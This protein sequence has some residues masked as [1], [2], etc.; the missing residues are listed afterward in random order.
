[1]DTK[2]LEEALKKA[3]E[4]VTEWAGAVA[5]ASEGADAGMK[6]AGNNIKQAIAEQKQ[7]IKELTDEIEKAREARD[8]MG[9]VSDKSNANIEISA[10]LKALREEKDRLTDMQNKA[11]Q[12][13][14]KEVGS[15]GGLIQSLGK[16]ALGLA[17]VAGAMKI[18]KEIIES[19]EVT[20][21]KFEQVATAAS[22]ATQYFFKTIATGDWTNFWSGIERA[23]K[24][25]FEYIDALEK[26]ENR[27]NE[28]TIKSSE[29]DVKIGEAR[30]ESFSTDPKVVKKALK[31]LITL[32]TEKL[33]GEAKIAKESY[34]LKRKKIADDNNWNETE[35]EN[36]IKFYTKNKEII[37]EGE[38]YNK[39]K[40]IRLILPSTS[41]YAPSSGNVAIYEKAQEE[42][43]KMGEEGAKAGEIAMG[44]SKIP[45]KVRAELAGMLA[46]SNQAT[47][48]ININNRRDKQRL[49]NIEKE[50]ET[51]RKA[52]AKKAKEDA[53]LDNRIKKTEDLIKQKAEETDIADTAELDALNKKLVLLNKEKE[54]REWLVKGAKAQAENKMLDN[55]G[56]QTALQALDDMFK[57]SGFKKDFLSL[58]EKGIARRN[59]AMAKQAREI[60]K[61][62]HI[63]TTEEAKKTA[64]AFFLVADASAQLAQNIGDSNREL[65]DTLMA[66]SR[67]A[68][69]F[70]KL[71]QGQFKLS[72]EQGVGMAISGATTMVGMFVSQAMENK[73][74]MDDYY[75][76]ISKQQQDYNMLLNEQLRLNSDIH[77]SVFLKDYEGTLTSST[78]A[79]NDAIARYQSEL[80]KFA[81]AQAITGKKDVVSGGNVLSGFGAGAALGAG[82]GAIAGGGVLS[83]PAAAAGAIIGGIAGAL[84]GLFA[85]KKKDIV[86]P[87]LETYKDL[88]TE[89]KGFNTALAETLITN[90]QVTDE[91]AKTLQ[92]L[93]DWKKAADAATEQ[94][95]SVIA[96]LTG[97]LGNDL[98]DA[99]VTAFQDGTDAAEAFKGSVNKILENIMSNMIFN[100]V[101]EGAFQNLEKSMAA[102]YGTGGDQS[103]L[104]D[105]QKFFSQS[106]ELIKN[107]NQGMKDFQTS[108]KDAG[109][110]VFSKTTAST[111]SNSSLTGQIA[112]SI[113][114]ETGNE[115]AGLYRRVADDTRIVRD[116]NK[117]AVNNLVAIEANTF[118]TVKELQKALIELQAI[119]KNTQQP[120][121]A[122]LGG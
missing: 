50:E 83:I 116:Y 5:K 1:M 8:K 29:L 61:K 101:F 62:E 27:K 19:T 20:A 12:A 39:L 113:T 78:K 84:A 111:T 76:S 58:D 70:G 52:A 54:F 119:N 21:H 45:L 94:L 109:F 53:E 6:K 106:P 88:Y 103:W 26:L 59:G 105:F 90:K 57:A 28:Q 86:A 44:F 67:L 120:Y 33:T 37:E 2:G 75:S 107:F 42:L 30:A 87:L 23:T 71:W 74:V 13:N 17:S 65:A 55:S 72:K 114:E 121:S 43:K 31:E 104:D 4:T 100:K 7:L 66:V 64:D 22:S 89:E 115:L 80:K 24:G 16:W 36:T 77:N 82:I 117:M 122:K 102:S 79:Y 46:A 91:T 49:V 41:S 97:S 63:Q 98:R 3:M 38:K 85:K 10:M 68:D 48:A 56:A 110:D 47:A 9:R 92:N 108:A 112:R 60:A 15:Q 14:E 35:L 32:Q 118:N 11:A 99:L 81:D 93:I 51:Q 96:D 40:A 73:K 34:E 18:S 95:K 25:A 69:Q